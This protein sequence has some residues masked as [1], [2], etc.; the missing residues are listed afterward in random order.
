MLFIN[1]LIENNNVDFENVFT[2]EELRIFMI[3]YW[4]NAI[5]FAKCPPVLQS[6]LNDIEKYCGTWGL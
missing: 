1:D 5:V 3:L 6:V 2:I 4:G